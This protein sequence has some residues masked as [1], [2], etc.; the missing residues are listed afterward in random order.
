MQKRAAGVPPT[1][2]PE[3]EQWELVHLIWDAPEAD[4]LTIGSVEPAGWQPVEEVV[5]FAV[6]PK[7]GQLVAEP[8]LRVVNGQAVCIDCS[9]YPS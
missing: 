2:I 1:E 3:A 5:R 7:C 6:C 8:Y 9:G 4:V